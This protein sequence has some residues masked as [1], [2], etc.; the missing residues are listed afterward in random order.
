MIFVLPLAAVVCDFC[1][2]NHNVMEINHPQTQPVVISR[3]AL[4][5]FAAGASIVFL[6]ALTYCYLTEHIFEMGLIA[7]AMVLLGG[8]TYWIYK[9]LDN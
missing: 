4:K 8:M 6:G 1:Y 7:G 5:L 9:G 2:T 3:R